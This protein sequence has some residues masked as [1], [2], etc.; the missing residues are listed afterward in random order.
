MADVSEAAVDAEY[1]AERDELL[2]GTGAILEKPDGSKEHIPVAE[3]FTHLHP[4]DSADSGIGSPAD[5][6]LK[7]MYDEA[8]S[9]GAD[10]DDE[11][12]RR[13]IKQYGDARVAETEHVR[14]QHYGLLKESMARCDRL[15]EALE[16]VRL[17]GMAVLNGVVPIKDDRFGA[18]PD[19]SWIENWRVKMLGEALQKVVS[20]Q[21]TGNDGG[22]G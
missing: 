21:A 11:T 7:Q 3:L 8:V 15:V 20:A 17:A 5:D 22:N 10:I 13:I 4:L 16:S 2:Y 18:G 12:A 6:C 19:K 14:D 9:P 1:L